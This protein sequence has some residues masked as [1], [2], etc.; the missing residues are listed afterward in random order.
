MSWVFALLTGI[1]WSIMEGARIHGEK[2]KDRSVVRERIAYIAGF[3]TL[4]FGSTL[5]CSILS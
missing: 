4:I 1:S 5:L 3:M 2:H